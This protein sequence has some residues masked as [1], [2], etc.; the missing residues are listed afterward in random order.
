MTALGFLTNLVEARSGIVV[1]A[2]K[3]YLFEARLAP[4]LRREGLVNLDQLAERVAKSGCSA[5]ECE[6]AEAMATHETLFFRDAKPFDHL[7]L[8]G[9]P[10]LLE[11]RRPG[12]KLRIWS[13]AASTGQEA[14]S[15]AITLAEMGLADR[16]RAEILATDLAAPALERARGGLYTQYEV[17]RGLS[18]Q[19]LL[20]HFDR[21]GQEWRVNAGLR[22][23]CRF[24]QWNLLE[25]P[26]PLGRFDVVF[27][28]NVLFYFGRPA[29]AAVLAHIRR[30]LASDG[31]LYLG[32]SETAAGIDD[33][34]K[35]DGP[36]YQ[37]C[38][39]TP[40]EDQAIA[41]RADTGQRHSTRPL[42]TPT[43]QS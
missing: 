24:R 29:R 40:L 11:Q 14:Y 25:D 7:R 9:L 30:H 3:D 5:L 32:A 39:S 34:L 8:V 38:S 28:R 22:A 21:E 15:L 31:L 43:Y 26:A 23:L 27:C 19:R 35:R 33:A 17:Q 18:V 10:A 12:T 4:I 37:T 2:G 42:R 20:Q 41:P 1:G 13:A 6:I 36:A 16:N